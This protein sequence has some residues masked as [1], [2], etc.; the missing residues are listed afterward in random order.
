MLYHGK[1]SIHLKIGYLNQIIT[2]FLKKLKL[3]FI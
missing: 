1:I 2:G 3:D